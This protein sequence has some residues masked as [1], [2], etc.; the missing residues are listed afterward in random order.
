MPAKKINILRP[1][2]FG[3]LVAL[4]FTTIFGCF[5]LVIAEPGSGFAHIRRQ[6]YLKLRGLLVNIWMLMC[7]L[8]ACCNTIVL[9][10]CPRLVTIL[11][12]M[13]PPVSST[14]RSAPS[15][16]IFLCHKAT[17]MPTDLKRRYVKLSDNLSANEY[18]QLLYW[19]TSFCIHHAKM[20]VVD[21]ILSYLAFLLEW[22]ATTDIS[23]DDIVW[24][25]GCGV[26]LCI[27]GWTL[28]RRLGR[29]NVLYCTAIVLILLGQW[30]P[31]S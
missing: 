3:A 18:F 30:C 1:W 12:Q 4:T 20:R 10:P 24:I 29:S 5:L 14:L 27:L 19:L 31:V 7:W 6:W 17:E 23:R 15:W 9:P 26:C 8:F 28:S 25:L 21:P 2:A 22:G 16:I 11:G 13:A